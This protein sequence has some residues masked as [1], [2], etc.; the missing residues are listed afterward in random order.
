MYSENQTEPIL[1]IIQQGLHNDVV[2][3][4]RKGI[5]TTENI[6]FHN[7]LLGLRLPWFPML[8]SSPQRTV[9]GQ[10]SSY[11]HGTVGTTTWISLNGSKLGSSSVAGYSG[12]VFEPIDEFKR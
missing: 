12:T 9:N 10:R 4:L 6:S 2:T 11:P 3:I 7:P 1:I 8:I 5:A